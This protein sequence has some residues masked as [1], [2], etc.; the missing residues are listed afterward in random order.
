[1]Q[2]VRR[3]FTTNVPRLYAPL[4]CRRTSVRV[5]VEDS[6]YSMEPPGHAYFAFSAGSAT[7]LN[8]ALG[9]SYW[10]KAITRGSTVLSTTSGQSLLLKILCMYV[11]LPAMY[12]LL[13]TLVLNVG[14]LH[15]TYV[16]R[17]SD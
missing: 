3:I 17:L 15:S 12:R 7:V 11:T 10:Q 14:I 4:F 13:P 2:A 5:L 1:M 9:T 6:R 8:Q 16:R